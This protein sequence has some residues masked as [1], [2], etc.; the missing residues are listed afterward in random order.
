M[1]LQTIHDISSLI[2]QRIHVL[3]LLRFQSSRLV[4]ASFSAQSFL[5]IR[6]ISMTGNIQTSHCSVIAAVAPQY[7]FFTVTIFIVMFFIKRSSLV[8][9]TPRSRVDQPKIYVCAQREPILVYYFDVF[10]WL[11]WCVVGSTDDDG[12]LRVCRDGRTFQ[13]MYDCRSC[14]P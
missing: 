13:H 8:V 1:A 14:D 12:T 10:F 4:Y 9:A 11:G 2:R 5:K 3:I 7:F 6:L